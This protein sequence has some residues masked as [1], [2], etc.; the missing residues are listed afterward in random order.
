MYYSSGKLD[1]VMPHALFPEKL[2]TVPIGIFLLSIILYALNELVKYA[3]VF[4][5]KR[6]Q[7]T[8]LA[9]LKDTPSTTSLTEGDES[10][11]VI[12]LP[13]GPVS[14]TTATEESKSSRGDSVSISGTGR[15]NNSNT[16]IHIKG[17]NPQTDRLDYCGTQDQNSQTHLCKKIPENCYGSPMEGEQ[18]VYPTS[19]EIMSVTDY[20]KTVRVGHIKA[21]PNHEH[22]KELAKL[23]H[24]GQTKVIVLTYDANKQKAEQPKST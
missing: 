5:S 15:P 21:G 1:A 2:V 9:I 7:Q 4:W 13:I 20:M 23:P 24:A 10:P 8:N 12:F 11:H 18:E 3:Q 16:H 22:I 17:N 14:P 19:E 6:A